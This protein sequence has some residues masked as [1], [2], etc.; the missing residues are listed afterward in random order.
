MDFTIYIMIV[1]FQM[2]KII[3]IGIRKQCKNSENKIQI[4]IGKIG[5]NNRLIRMFRISNIDT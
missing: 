5:E 4:H 1:M 3:I 2:I